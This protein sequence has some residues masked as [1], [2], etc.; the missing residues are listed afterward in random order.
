MSK[1][2]LGDSDGGDH[3]FQLVTASG[4]LKGL[5]VWASEGL[6]VLLLH[7]VPG[8]LMCSLKIHQAVFFFFLLCARCVLVHILIFKI[9]R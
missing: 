1:A 5:W 8:L 7:P 6:L 9:K 3:C 2:N 4:S